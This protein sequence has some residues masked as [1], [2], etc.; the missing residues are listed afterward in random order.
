MNLLTLYFGFSFY[1]QE[2][3]FRHNFGKLENK[4]YFMEFFIETMNNEQNSNYYQ[5]FENY[6]YMSVL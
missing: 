4:N 6:F 3:W 1:P 5:V 2:I